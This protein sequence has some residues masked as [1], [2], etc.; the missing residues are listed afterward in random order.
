MTGYLD[1]LKDAYNFMNFYMTSLPQTDQEW[2]LLG[3]RIINLNNKYNNN[4]FAGVIFGEVYRAISS[5]AAKL[6]DDSI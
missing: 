5:C 3:D 4:D 1:V 6:N 2:D